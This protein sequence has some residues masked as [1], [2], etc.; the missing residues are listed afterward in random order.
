MKYILSIIFTLT[1]SIVYLCACSSIDKS[2]VIVY[3]DAINTNGIADIK[4]AIVKSQPVKWK[5]VID[6]KGNPLYALDSVGYKNLSTTIE[7]AQ[8]SLFMCNQTLI[9]RTEYFQNKK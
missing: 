3:K 9:K 8:N 2:P 4:Q 7:Q 6:E 5:I 1:L